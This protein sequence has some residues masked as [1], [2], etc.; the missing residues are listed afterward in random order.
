MQ[1]TGDLNIDLDM[2]VDIAYTVN[3][4]QLT[5]P[6][7]QGASKGVFKPADSSACRCGL[8]F[9]ITFDDGLYARFPFFVLFVFVFVLVFC[10]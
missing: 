10:A 1:A 2:K 7:D 6:P 5:F 3:N 8:L 9:R 4:A